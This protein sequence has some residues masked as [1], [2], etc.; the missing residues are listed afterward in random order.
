MTGALELDNLVAVAA[1]AFLASFVVPATPYA[2]PATLAG[3]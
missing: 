1:A 2:A 3:G